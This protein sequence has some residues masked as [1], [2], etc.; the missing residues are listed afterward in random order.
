MQAPIAD[1][2]GRSNYPAQNYQGNRVSQRG[3]AS[4]EGS[5]PR[6]KIDG[7]KADAEPDETQEQRQ[8]A[9]G[10]RPSRG[11]AAWESARRLWGRQCGCPNTRYELTL[12]TFRI[13]GCLSQHL[14]YNTAGLRA[15]Q[16][17][18]GLHGARRLWRKFFGFLVRRW[19]DAD[20]YR[21]HSESGEHECRGEQHLDLDRE[22]GDKCFDHTWELHVEPR[23]RL[24][25][26]E[27]DCD[28]DLHTDRDQRSGFYYVASDNYCK[29]R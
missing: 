11:T 22:W 10:L 24:H 16:H 4:L 17:S 26:R 14:R 7:A 18:F 29:H 8:P 23:V 9:V 12:L 2:A 5:D 15:G 25:E 19:L 6:L 20:Y 1:P 13:F 3:N 21:V 27:P 28:D